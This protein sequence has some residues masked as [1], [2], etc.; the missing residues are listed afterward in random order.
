MAAGTETTTKSATGVLITYGTQVVATLLITLIGVMGT[1]LTVKIG[2][3]T[4]LENINSAQREVICAG[5]ITVGELQRTIV[6][7]LK[8]AREDDK[9]TKQ[10]IAMLG[11]RLLDQTV[12]KL[13]MQ[14]YELLRAAYMDINALITGVGENWINKLKKE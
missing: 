9:L 7:D 11:Q 8:A 1:W 6:D 14:T 4:E 2:K 13:S 3:H 10:E 5:K 12:Q